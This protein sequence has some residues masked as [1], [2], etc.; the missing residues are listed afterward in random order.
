[1]LGFPRAVARRTPT[2]APSSTNAGT[3]RGSTARRVF[4]LFIAVTTAGAGDAHSIC[5]RL[6]LDGFETGDL[7]GWTV[8]R[9]APCTSWQ[10]QLTGTIDTSF[11]V[12]MYDIDLFDVPGATIDQL[13]SDGRTVVCYFSAGSWESW[14]PDAGS[15]PESV[16]GLPLDPPFED[17][18]WLDIRQLAI[19]GPIMEARL[20]LTVTKGCDGVEPDNVDGYTN[21]TGFPLTAV[22]QLV[23]NRFLAAKAHERGL[24]V[25]LKNDL[26]QIPD[27]VDAFDWALD[28]QCWEFDECDTLAPF[29]E[30]GKA[31]FG[32]E[33][34][35]DPA[36]FC[37]V[38][39]ALEYSWLKKNLDLDAFRIDC[40]DVAAPQSLDGRQ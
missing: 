22:D 28:E 32:V 30:R 19:L 17:E 13:H 14:R 40:R 27:L 1:M 18:L 36:V 25:G 5:E 8:W 11:D 31:V 4:L 9:P 29:V 35:G 10:W 6:F 33:Y 2:E 24:S 20:D 34:Q 16:K 12:D 7:S 38:L 37:P 39:N 26:D 3:G 21:T 15:F 23:Y